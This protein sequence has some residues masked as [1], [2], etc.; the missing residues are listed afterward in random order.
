MARTKLDKTP[1]D[2]LAIAVTPVLIMLL[3]GSLVF[4]LQELF[5]T[6]ASFQS[7]T[8]WILFWF[9][10]GMVLIARIG[11]ESGRAQASMFTLLLGGVTALAIYKFE[12]NAPGSAIIC[13]AIIWWCTDKLTWD[14]TLIDESEDASGEGL[15]QVAGVADEAELQTGNEQAESAS[16]DQPADELQKVPLWKRLF[17]NV[18]ERKDKPHAPGLWVVYFSLAA[19]PLFGFGQAMIPASNEA[20]RDWAF[21]CLLVY[22]ASGLGLLLLTSFLGLRRYLRQRNLQMPTKMAATWVGMG[23]TIA[24]GILIV[25]LLMPRPQGDYSV[26]DLIDRAGDELQEASDMAFLDGDKGEGEGEGRRI[27]DT[28]ENANQGAAQKQDQQNAQPGGNQPGD[29]QDQNGQQQGE[30]GEPGEQKGEGQQQNQGDGKGDQQSD[31]AQQNDNQQKP[32]ESQEPQGNESSEQQRDSQQNP[33]NQNSEQEQ[34]NASN[35]QQA[36]NKS[37]EDEQ[38]RQEAQNENAQGRQN[39]QEQQQNAGDT[40]E[41]QTAENEGEQE[42]PEQSDESSPDEFPEMEPPSMAESTEWIAN[43]FKFV[44]YGTIA[45]FFLWML[46]RHWASV[47][48]F[49]SRLWNEFLSIFSRKPKIVSDSDE[50]EEQIAP[51]QPFAAFRN[52]FSSGA[53]SQHS[54]SELVRYTFEAL[55]AWAF[56]NG[57]ERSPDQT[58]MEF[59]R[60]LRSSK[61]RFSSE[62]DEV[63]QLY[64]Q[65]AYAGH[66]PKSESLGL[67]ENLWRKM[68]AS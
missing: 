65:V 11:I 61:V 4:F 30:E 33:G 42:Q 13:L 5:S 8:H 37:D 18:S 40:G 63:S 32:N 3:V 52:P 66:R 36:N 21:R 14:C 41:Q 22:V 38:N 26:T 45:L 6:G 48:H 20:S 55:Q 50:I 68:D 57:C 27:G 46:N 25:A 53:V 9:V 23:A 51:P 56:E 43:L 24:I 67:L 7:R 47:V 49:L 15:L 19:L 54:P 17:L 62:A 2:Y 59:G 31:Q 34:N 29:K 16:N 64:A 12:R 60:Q 58:P 44:V 10:L 28:D 35:E 1:A 39:D